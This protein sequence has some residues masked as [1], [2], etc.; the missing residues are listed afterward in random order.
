MVDYPITDFTYMCDG[1]K[2]F[3]HY[4]RIKKL[5]FISK[6]A[7]GISQIGCLDELGKVSIWNIVEVS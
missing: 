3:P 2:D 5:T 6:S 1:L 4:G 7:S